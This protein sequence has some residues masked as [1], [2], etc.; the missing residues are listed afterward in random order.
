M[1]MR[2][3]EH[4]LLRVSYVYFGKAGRIIHQNDAKEDE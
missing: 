1:K 2:M 3:N 4:T